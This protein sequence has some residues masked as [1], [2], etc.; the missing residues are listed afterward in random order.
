MQSTPTWPTF[1]RTSPDPVAT[2]LRHCSGA[3][4]A[5]AWPQKAKYYR[6]VRARL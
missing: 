5:H 1:A 2:F 3:A 4:V 6:C